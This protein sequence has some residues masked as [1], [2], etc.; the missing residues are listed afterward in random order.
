MHAL[1]YIKI[2]FQYNTDCILSALTM[3][4]SNKQLQVTESLES[5]ATKHDTVWGCTWWGKLVNPTD[6]WVKNYG[7]TEP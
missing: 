6:L 5:V 3:Q 1:G 7:G 4:L 2:Q